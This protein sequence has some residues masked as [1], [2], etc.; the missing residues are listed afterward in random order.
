MFLE[1]AVETVN[2]HVCSC[3]LVVTG[4]LQSAVYLFSGCCPIGDSNEKEQSIL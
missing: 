1:R 4:M 3:S 2:H